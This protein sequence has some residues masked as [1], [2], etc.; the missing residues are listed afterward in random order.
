LSLEDAAKILNGIIGYLSVLEKIYLRMQNK[1]NEPKN[2]IFKISFA[3]H[4]NP[5]S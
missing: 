1:N 2:F 5:F 3:R 4:K